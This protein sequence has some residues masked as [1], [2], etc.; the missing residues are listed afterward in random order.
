MCDDLCWSRVGFFVCKSSAVHIKVIMHIHVKLVL[1]FAM[2]AL[3][4]VLGVCGIEARV[5]GH[6]QAPL[7]MRAG[8]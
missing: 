1:D 8:P 5:G 6:T 7:I 3:G 2:W 4:D